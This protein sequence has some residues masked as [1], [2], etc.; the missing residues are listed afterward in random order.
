[1]TGTAGFFFDAP[2]LTGFARAA[3]HVSRKSGGVRMEARSD[4][5]S[6]FLQTRRPARQTFPMP[7]CLAPDFP[8]YL[9]IQ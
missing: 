7:P 8:Q 3:Y 2:T 1:M 9:T 4:Q 5:E 6:C